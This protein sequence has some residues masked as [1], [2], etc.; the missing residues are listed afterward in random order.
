MNV[1]MTATALRAA[2]LGV[3]SLVVAAASTLAIAQPGPG[4]HGFGGPM[5]MFGGSTEH[6]GRMIDH[7]L[8]GLNATDAQRTQI[9]QIAQAAAA[10]LKPQ[11]D[12][13]RA[14]QERA[15]QIF[16]TPTVDATAAEQVRQQMLAQHD[17]L[18]R[19]TLAA[20]IEISRVLSPEQ[21]TKIGERMKQRSEAMR[22]RDQRM[23]RAR[24]AQ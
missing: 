1:S 6:L 24:P 19:R 20:T 7:M 5:M 16:T 10:D 12:A 22:E 4:G 15:M 18:S 8:D 3:A 21:R 14:L 17:Q 23:E 13:A 9:K 2:R 11:R